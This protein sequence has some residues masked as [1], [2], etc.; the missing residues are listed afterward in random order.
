MVCV[1]NWINV[2]E[3]SWHVKFMSGLESKRHDIDMR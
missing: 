3:G 1:I 2:I